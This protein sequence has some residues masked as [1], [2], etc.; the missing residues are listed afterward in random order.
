MA[1][2]TLKKVICFEKDPPAIVD[3]NRIEQ[4]ENPLKKCKDFETDESIVCLRICNQRLAVCTKR[5]SFKQLRCDSI[6][7]LYQ[8]PNYASINHS[9]QVFFFFFRKPTMKPVIQGMSSA[10]KLVYASHVSW[11]ISTQLTA[12]RIAHQHSCAECVYW[13]V[14]GFSI[15]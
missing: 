15:P 2:R 12:S 1:V 8:A 3:Y 5:F 9:L 6:N 13:N 11:V 4:N 10:Y 14:L 7:Y